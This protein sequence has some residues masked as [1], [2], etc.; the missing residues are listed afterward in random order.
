MYIATALIP[1]FVATLPMAAMMTTA[2]IINPAHSTEIKPIQAR[3]MQMMAALTMLAM[4][5]KRS[6]NDFCFG[7]CFY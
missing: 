6:K 7:C 5:D 2:I 1:N 4:P 3:R